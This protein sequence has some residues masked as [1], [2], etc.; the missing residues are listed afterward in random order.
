MNPSI[1]LNNGTEHPM[2]GL[3]CYKLENDQQA[4]EILSLAASIGYR[5]FDTASSYRNEEGI[6]RGLARSGVAR[7]DFF[8]TTKIWNNA[9][10][11]GDVEQAF[12]RSL[13]RLGLDY[14]D[15]YL[16]HW[17]VPGCFIDTWNVMEDLYRAGKAKAIGVCNFT[18]HDL[19][20]LLEAATVKPCVN[21]IEYHLLNQP[22]QLISFCKA[23]DIAIEAYSPLARGNYLDRQVITSLAEKYHRSPAQIGLRFLVQKNAC[24]IPKTSKPERLLENSQIF[25]FELEQSEME[26]LELLNEDFKVSTVPEDLQL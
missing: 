13:S 17:P 12:E 2:L 3:G 1:S 6:G 26:T 14:V 15:E 21:Q 16:I 22:D 20:A 25:D 19:D 9:Q 18:L 11:M 5:W 7:E 24:V 10:R 8:I 23:N 4:E